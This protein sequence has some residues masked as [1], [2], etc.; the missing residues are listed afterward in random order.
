MYWR[1]PLS[2][3][4]S[5]PSLIDII[6]AN[7]KI[8]TTRLQT[9]LSCHCGKSK[10]QCW[11]RIL[12]CD[13]TSDPPRNSV[14]WPD[15]P[16]RRPLILAAVRPTARVSTPLRVFP[17]LWALYSMMIDSPRHQLFTLSILVATNTVLDQSEFR[18]LHNS[19]FLMVLLCSFCKPSIYLVRQE[20][21]PIQTA[22]SLLWR[23]FDLE[24]CLPPICL[25]WL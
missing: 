4:F 23:L 14:K 6:N 17:Q 9:M 12:C 18:C 22:G 8:S 5:E 20:D 25:R 10:W 24:F 19:I 16:G 7:L 15:A 3:R 11:E 13:N 1:L 2:G 21:R